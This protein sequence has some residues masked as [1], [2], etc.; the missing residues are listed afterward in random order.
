MVTSSDTNQVV[1]ILL[2]MVVG[3][4]PCTGPGKADVQVPQKKGKGVA[5]FV[6]VN[7]LYE[8]VCDVDKWAAGAPAGGGRAPEWLCDRTKVVLF[9]VVYFLAGCDF[10]PGMHSTTSTR[11]LKHVTMTVAMPRLFED[12]IVEDC[13][14]RWRVHIERAV[15]VLCVC[16]FKE[17]AD[18]FQTKFAYG[19]A[20][21]LDAAHVRRDPRR[22]AHVVQ[23]TIWMAKGNRGKKNCPIWDPLVLQTQRVDA[24]LE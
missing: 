1:H 18:V 10:L 7:R 2:A 17:D 12:P 21:L 6:L 3:A 13:D 22:F 5:N 15:K 16:Y 11:M 19:A 14:G 23:D 4:I 9:V 24:V 20:G 8:A